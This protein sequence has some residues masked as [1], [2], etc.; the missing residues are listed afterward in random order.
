MLHMHSAGST[1]LHTPATPA[2]PALTATACRSVCRYGCPGHSVV[3]AGMVCIE[4][5]R[6]DGSMSTFLMVHNS[7]LM[8]TIGLLGSE[9]QKKVMCYPNPCMGCRLLFMGCTSLLMQTSASGPTAADC[10]EQSLTAFAWLSAQVAAGFMLSSSTWGVSSR[11]ERAV[12]QSSPLRPAE[13]WVWWQHHPSMPCCSGPCAA[14]HPA[15][16][17]RQGIHVLP[18]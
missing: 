15:A 10:G 12:S 14:V 7:L 18:G 5:A 3:E 11:G 1:W 8:L 6:V 9:Q 17:F 4:L 2:K 16:A 13:T